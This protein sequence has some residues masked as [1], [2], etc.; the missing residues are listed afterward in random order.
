M[1]NNANN[2]EKLILELHKI[3]AIKFGE[4]KLKSGLISPFYLD[5][6]MIVAYPALVNLIADMLIA[7]IKDLKFDVITGIPYTAL[8]IAA[9]MSIKLNKPLIYIRKEDKAYGTGKKI[10]GK[11]KPN[12][13]CL[14]IDDVMTTGDSKIE[15][16]LEL[17][18]AG[19]KITDMAI[20]ID[21]SNNGKQFLKT[22]GYDL[23]SLLNVDEMISILSAH[24]LLNA[25]QAEKI[26]TFVAN[27]GVTKKLS[28]KERV[29]NSKNPLTK[30]LVDLIYQKKSNLVL[31]LD[32]N[33]SK[34]FFSILNDTASEIVLLKTHVDIINDFDASFVTRLLKMAAEYNFLILEDRKFADIG[35]TVKMQYQQGIYKIADWAE[36]VTVHTVAGESILDG[37]FKGLNL[38]RSAFLLSSMSAAGNL[39]SDSY[40][41]R[42]IEIGAK[43]C[44]HVTGFIGFGT[45]RD[46]IEKLKN[47]IPQ[48]LLLAMPG[49]NLTATGDTL[50][51][52]YVT[53][54]D[55]VL[56]GADIIIVGRGIYASGNVREN[57]ELYRKTAWEAF[58]TVNSR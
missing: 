26:K 18:K 39:I 37:L 14:V 36:F 48:D 32:V 30:K 33:N 20:V 57:A 46:E 4:F 56:G 41:R 6:R 35:N 15:L 9:I 11:Y 43:H 12:D 55:A 50:G 22:H 40:T 24:D 29:A 44:E 45:N 16:A 19:V 1:A 23:Y 34:E 53:V 17:E 51:Q 21:R 42:T 52:R 38:A 13:V 2:Q 58:K 3:G 8:P 31:S 27:T 47:K 49:V 25:E 28:L 54:E 10:E 5:L 7:K